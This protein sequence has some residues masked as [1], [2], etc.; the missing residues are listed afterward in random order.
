MLALA[1]EDADEFD[2]DIDAEL[3]DV[4]ELNDED[5]DLGEME[6]E[7]EDVSEPP[8]PT[9][10]ANIVAAFANKG[11]Q[12]AWCVWVNPQSGQR[13][14]L[15]EIKAGTTFSLNSFP[16][17][18]IL[19]TDSPD[20]DSNVLATFT[21]TEEAQQSHILT[22]DGRAVTAGAG[23]S[24]KLALQNKLGQTVYVHWKNPDDGTEKLLIEIESDETKTLNSFVA[25][26]LYIRD[27]PTSSS[28]LQRE[29]EVGAD[30][31]QTVM[32][33][34]DGQEEDDD[35]EIELGED[36]L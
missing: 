32:L 35:I 4:E 6:D 23:G 19:L 9:P 8:A 34:Y 14:A 31:H 28:Q 22:H 17:Q 29:L 2:E 13:H 7:D 36:E 15:G 33:E 11:A 1:D 30:A 27:G 16:R 25:H 5:L 20:E 10:P 26:M 3:D 21:T 24:V 18:T 12:T